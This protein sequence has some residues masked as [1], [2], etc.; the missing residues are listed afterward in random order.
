MPESRLWGGATQDWPLACGPVW[1]G[2]VAAVRADGTTVAA[3]TAAVVG[4]PRRV[5]VTWQS[6]W[7]P[8]WRIVTY[9]CNTWSI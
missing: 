5:A 6:A 8:V 7:S 1:D 2:L 3:G 9:S 4:E